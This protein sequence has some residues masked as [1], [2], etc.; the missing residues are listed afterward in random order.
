MI[1]YHCTIEIHSQTD[2]LRLCAYQGISRA[3]VSQ[4]VPQ[5]DGE[6]KETDI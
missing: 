4:I 1:G 5:T 3:H 2:Q 6:T